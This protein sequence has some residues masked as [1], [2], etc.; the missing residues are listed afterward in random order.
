MNV[1][2]QT[3]LEFSAG[4]Y[5][6]DRLRFNRYSAALQMCTATNDHEQ[7]N[8]AMDRIK[9]F[10]YSELADTVF[11]NQE[12]FERAEVLELLG[13]NITTLPQDPIDQI[14]GL[15][16]YTKLSAITEGRIIIDALD[17]SSLLGDNV[18]YMFESGDNLGPF[19]ND[20]WWNQPDTSHSKLENIK[21]EENVVKV[22]TTGW[23]KYNLNWNDLS[24]R[25]SGKTVEFEK[26]LGDAK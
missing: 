18:V 11:I 5:F 26:L 25:K 3:N 9:M 15:M 4:I 10:V 14:I 7:I 12:D 13:V 1:K 6:E 23:S 19:C 16:L 21:L 17:I 24:T 20:G 2:L 8:I 22:P